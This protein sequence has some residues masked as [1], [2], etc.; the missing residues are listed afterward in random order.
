MEPIASNEIQLKIV[1]LFLC[2]YY[3]YII[4]ALPTG[5]S[6]GDDVILQ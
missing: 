5:V 6:K 3:V 2:K 1:V 4:K